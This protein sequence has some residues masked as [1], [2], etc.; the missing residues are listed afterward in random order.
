MNKDALD[1]AY[2]WTLPFNFG[3]AYTQVQVIYLNKEMQLKDINLT[4]A[5]FLYNS[6]DVTAALTRD[7]RIS[8]A[9]TD[10]DYFNIVDHNV[11]FIDAD[12]KTVY[13][14]PITIKANK[15]N[16]PV[17]IT[18]DKPYT[19]K[20]GNIVVKYETLFDN[21]YVTDTQQPL[22]H[23][24]DNYDDGDP[25]YNRSAIWRSETSTEVVNSQIG[26]MYWTPFTMFS[27]DTANGIG[28]L[29]APTNAA[30]NLTQQGNTLHFGSKMDQVEIV[31]TS[32]AIVRSARAT[33]SLNVE[34]LH[35]AYL[36]RV[37]VAGKTLTMKYVIK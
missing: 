32:G 11:D 16:S 9:E 26:V 28:G 7:V 33:S 18:F 10:R 20:G 21:N 22:W 4:G 5:Q 19:Y 30:F 31:S 1:E 15:L 24:A 14:G 8:I 36:V 35:G 12:Y 25:L 17:T 6:P 3:D 27:Y 34:G 29:V 23:Y 37:N 13:E 2:G